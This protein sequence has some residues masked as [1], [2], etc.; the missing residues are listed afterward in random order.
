ME[1]QYFR[2]HGYATPGLESNLAECVISFILT[3]NYF[4]PDN[5]NKYDANM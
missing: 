1:L 2:L 3:I 5:H 4:T